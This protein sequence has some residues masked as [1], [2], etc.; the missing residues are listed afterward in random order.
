MLVL[1]HVML[2]GMEK[3]ID[4]EFKGMTPIVLMS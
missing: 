1:K 4:K 3:E 2:E